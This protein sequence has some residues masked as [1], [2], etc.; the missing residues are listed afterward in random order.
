ML[1][2]DI[3]NLNKYMFSLLKGLF[4]FFVLMIFYDILKD[5]YMVFVEAVANQLVPF[6]R[7]ISQ[8]TSH[9]VIYIYFP[10]IEGDI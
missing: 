8:A 3:D 7:K 10:S 4:Y 5:T 9:C 6:A 2:I 1:D